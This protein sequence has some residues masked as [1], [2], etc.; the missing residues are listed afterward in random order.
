MQDMAL[1]E[2]Q[3]YATIDQSKYSSFCVEKT[4]TSQSVSIVLCKL[5]NC[6]G[7]WS[8][9]KSYVNLKS[10]LTSMIST[11]LVDDNWHSFMATLFLRGHGIFKQHDANITNIKMVPET[12]D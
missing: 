10:H 11:D 6:A 4:V 1:Q 5:C 12:L 3:H 2:P 8:S 9:Q 7:H